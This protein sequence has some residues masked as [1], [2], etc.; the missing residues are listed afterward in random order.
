MKVPYLSATRLKMIKD[1]SLAY[2]MQYDPPSQEARVLKE[3]SNHPSNLAA[4]FLGTNLHNAL[5]EWRR[6]DENGKT[7]K[8][9]LPR[10]IELYK[11]ECSKNMLPPSMY[12]DGKRM[13]QRWFNRRGKDPVRVLGVEMP[14]GSHRAPYKTK[15]GVPV[16]G[17]VDLVLEHKDGTIELVDYKSQRAP[18]TQDEADTDVQ[19]GM[20]LVVAREIW[21]DRPLIFSFDLLRY[22]VV[23]SVWPEERIEAFGEWLKT[24]YDYIS[25]L[26]EGTA[27]IS[28]S[29]QYCSYKS[30]CPRVEDLMT[31]DLWDTLIN[32]DGWENDNEMLSELQRIKY[33]QGILNK[34][35]SKIEG[36]IKSRFA[37]VDPD[38][39]RIDTDEWSLH[40]G[41][42]DRKEYIPSEVQRHVPPAVFGQLVTISKSRLEAAMDV[43][44]DETVKEI[45]DSAVTKFGRRLSI[46]K[47][48][49]V[50]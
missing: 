37:G 33:A 15:L 10:L 12:E 3:A 38:E 50:E 21:P 22:G 2:Q 32:A 41:T 16:F 39:A 27:S 14:F 1:C 31:E 19:A 23:S 26:T 35:R 9:R 34:Q 13:L 45:Q 42:Q 6:P 11:E 4:A 49:A 40:W 29:C 25:N 46:R 7:P 47:R 17:M 20:Y 5:E 18:I 43:L 48:P 24:Q 30:I 8:P 28:G 44:D 36:E